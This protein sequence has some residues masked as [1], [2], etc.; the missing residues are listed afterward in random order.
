MEVEEKDLHELE[1]K[2]I[3]IYKLVSQEKLYEKFF[4]E[5]S[6]LQRPYRYKNELIEELVK[7]DDSVDF[8][9]T[10]ILEV[11]ELKEEKPRKKISFI[12][13]LEEQDTESLLNKYGL[14]KLEDI[15]DMDLNVLLKYF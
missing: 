4:F 11:E 12:N 8:L 1:E 7:M 13:I 2:L 3:L 10:C 15:Q 5:D 14:D 9:K 6:N